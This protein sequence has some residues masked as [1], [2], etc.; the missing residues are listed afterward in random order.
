MCPIQW[1]LVN[2]FSKLFSTT[3]YIVIMWG[4]NMTWRPIYSPQWYVILPLLLG[5]RG[6]TEATVYLYRGPWAPLWLIATNEAALKEAEGWRGQAPEARW[7]P[8]VLHPLAWGWRARQP[9]PWPRLTRTGPPR[10][11]HSPGLFYFCWNKGLNYILQRR[12]K[13]NTC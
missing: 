3:V 7:R 2:L 4:H 13:N 10:Y 12:S 5:I 9:P 8:P 11:F 1:N 6:R